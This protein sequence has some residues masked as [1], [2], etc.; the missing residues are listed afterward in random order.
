MPSSRPFSPSKLYKSPAVLNS[1]WSTLR[2]VTHISAASSDF[3]LMEWA[4]KQ[5][6]RAVCVKAVLFLCISAA[7]ADSRSAEIQQFLLEQNRLGAVTNALLVQRGG[8]EQFQYYGAD[9]AAGTPGQLYSVSKSVLALGIVAAAEQSL[10]SLDDSICKWIRISDNPDLCDIRVSH[11]LTMSSGLDWQ[12]SLSGISLSSDATELM[13]GCGSLDTVNFV[14]SRK[15]ASVPGS[16]FNYSSGDSTLLSAVLQKVTN[17]NVREFFQKTVF[18]RIGITSPVWEEDR[19]GNL[20]GAASLFLTAPELVKIG[21]LMLGNGTGTYGRVMSEDSVRLLLSPAF[22]STAQAYGLSWWLNASDP[23][24]AASAENP[25]RF[26]SATAR[27]FAALGHWGQGII[28]VPED[29]LIIVRLADDK[30]ATFDFDELI[31]RV[32][33]P[34]WDRF[35]RESRRVKSSV[36]IGAIQPMFPLRRLV[37]APPLVDQILGFG[38]KTSCSCRHVSNRPRVACNDA[39]TLPELSRLDYSEFMSSSG[40]PGRPAQELTV[41]GRTEGWGRAAVY[42]DGIGCMLIGNAAYPVRD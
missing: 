11:L 26:P 22:V 13:Y 14:L 20:V 16:V 2:S 32:R 19:A 41:E 42:N 38:A 23:N 37:Y 39:A 15:L 25:F 30:Q 9:F 3:R 10:L 28:V 27:T 1:D 8:V 12:E 35:A 31:A 18:S 36:P 24:H 33:G 7:F 21:Q 29:E 6:L 40:E 5:F 17:G 34:S 4:V